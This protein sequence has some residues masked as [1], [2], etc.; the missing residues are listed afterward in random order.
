V[1]HS[2]SGSHP[3][4]FVGRDL[5]DEENDKR[6]EFGLFSILDIL[7]R[8]AGVDRNTFRLDDLTGTRSDMRAVSG[9]R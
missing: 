4:N 3:S 5:G 1:R 8:E 7:E 6:I 2:F 9:S